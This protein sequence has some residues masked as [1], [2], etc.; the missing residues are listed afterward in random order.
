MFV[1]MGHI[2]IDRVD[3]KKNDDIF[4]DLIKGDKNFLKKI[5]MSNAK[6]L[7]VSET[8]Q[9]RFAELEQYKP[10]VQK[11]VTKKFGIVKTAKINMDENN[12]KEM[13]I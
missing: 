11:V 10:V 8:A 12:E 6:N 5:V 1:Q 3:R 9:K 4:Q 2:K 13:R 7:E